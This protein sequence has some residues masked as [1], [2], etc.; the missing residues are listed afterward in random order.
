MKEEGGSF[1]LLPS[2]FFLLPSSF[3]VA[4]NPV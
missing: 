3:L 1:F 4:Y 2:S